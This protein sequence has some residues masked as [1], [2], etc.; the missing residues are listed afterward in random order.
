MTESIYKKKIDSW[1]DAHLDEMIEDLKTLVRIPSIRGDA[2]E[3]M[4]YGEEPARALEAMRGLMASY[5]LETQNYGNHCV[6]GD[7]G[8]KE[9]KALDILAHLDVVP[10]SD[11]WKKTKPFEPLVEGDLIYGRGTSDDKGPAVAAL[12]ALRA[13]RELGIELTHGV[14][15]ICGSDEECGSGDLDYYYSK[16]KEAEYTFTPDADYPLINIEKG[17]LASVFTASAEQESVNDLQEGQG[18]AFR[19]LSLHA[20]DT[21]N[22]IPGSAKVVLSDADRALLEKAVGE[23]EQETGARITISYENGC[24]AVDVAGATGHA[25]HPDGSLNALTASLSLLKRLPLADRKGEHM[26]LAAADLWPHGEYDGKTLGVNYEDEESGA[27]TMSLD[28]LNYEVMNER[29]S[30]FVLAG[31]FDCRAPICA[32]DENLT[33]KVRRQLEEKGFRMQEG[34]LKPV[35]YVPADSELVRKL[36]ASYELYFGVKGKPVAIGG[37]TY[38]HNL[39]RGVAFGCAETDVDNR[40]HGDDEFMKI[41]ILCRSAKIFADAVIRLCG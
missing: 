5:G 38:V 31:C 10:V 27:L 13:I 3:G 24:C 4:P 18:A 32:N 37:G 19:V 41:S 12:Y 25:A 29:E 1:M 34:D 30:A 6:T 35:H 21:V 14:R 40:M 8:G 26:L 2:K 28:V 39:E 7:L 20:G 22:V 11:T 16:E 9:E 15:L 17:R 23:T 33:Q 36:L